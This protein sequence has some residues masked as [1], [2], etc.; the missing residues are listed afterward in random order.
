M[1]VNLRPL[2]DAYTRGADGR[3]VDYRR[4]TCG[5]RPP[6]DVCG[7]WTF[8]RAVFWDRR[9]HRALCAIDAVIRVHEKALRP[10]LELAGLD[11]EMAD[12]R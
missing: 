3:F 7:S 5:E 11:V 4:H 10:P 2:S 6:C 12:S 8:K 9:R 1:A